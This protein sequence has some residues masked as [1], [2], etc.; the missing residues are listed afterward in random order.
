MSKRTFKIRK[1]CLYLR[2]I[3]YKFINPPIFAPPIFDYFY[4]SAIA[5]L[6][7]SFE[8]IPLNIS[9]Y[10]TFPLPDSISSPG[11][12][13]FAVPM[14][15][16]ISR[17]A[18]LLVSSSLSST[19]LIRYSFYFECKDTSFPFSTYAICAICV[20]SGNKVRKISW[21][22]SGE[23]LRRIRKYLR[24]IAQYLRRIRNYL[25]KIAEYLRRIT[26]EDKM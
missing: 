11:P 10:F 18:F 2:F 16:L 3:N 21:N 12:S 14:K 13:C 22:H 9:C 6:I 19:S 23:Y 1:N 17:Y 5:I 15:L 24:K 8:I 26:P 20:D 4:I 7:S 25:R